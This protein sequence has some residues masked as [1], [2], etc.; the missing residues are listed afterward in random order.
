MHIVIYNCYIVVFCG[1]WILD[2][3]GGMSAHAH[4][5]HRNN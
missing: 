5:I 4:Y 2:I 1:F 3:T